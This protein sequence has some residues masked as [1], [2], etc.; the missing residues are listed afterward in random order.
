ARL[1]QLIEES[2]TG[3]KNYELDKAT[4]P[5]TDFIDDLS[6]WYLRRSRDRL[7]GEDATDKKLALETLRFTL[8]QLSLV[9]APSMPFYAD[10]L[11]GRVKEDGDEDSVHLS[12]WPEVK[13]ADPVVIGEMSLVREFVTAS[14]EARTKAG[15]KVRQPLSKLTL[16][17]EMEPEYTSIICDEVNVKEVAFDSSSDQRVSLDTNITPELKQE[18]DARDFIRAVQDLRKEKGLA[19][20]DRI[21][22]KVKTSDE[23]RAVLENFDS[24]IKRVVGAD[25][26]LYGEAEGEEVKAGENTFILELHVV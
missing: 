5:L 7:K 11:W 24:D 16:N 8:R 21:T 20:S 25:S 4:R 14:L 15:I 9:M 1:N 12:N 2:T 17:I 22:L 26:I 19:P 23:G 10:Y 6:V 18:G 13:T 3:F